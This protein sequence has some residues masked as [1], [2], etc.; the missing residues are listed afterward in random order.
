MNEVLRGQLMAA[1]IAEQPAALARLL[2]TAADQIAPIADAIRARRPRFA[3][4]AARGTSDH[5]ALYAKYLLEILAGLPVGLASP[6]TL[7]VFGSEPDL[8]EVLWIA[9]SQSGGSP[10]LVDSTTVARRGGAITLGVTN[11]SASPLAS[12]CEFHIDVH[13]GPERAVAATK[14]YSN[15]LLAL[16][17]L[18]DRL[19]GGDGRAADALPEAAQAIVDINPGAE[20][21]PRYRFVERIVT[22]GRGYA[23]PTAR[24]GALKLMETSYVAAHS[25]S[26]A[27]L[28]HGPFAMIDEDRPVVAIVPE[29]LGGEAMRPV[30][31]R[32]AERGADVLAIGDPANAPDATVTIALPRGIAEEVSPIL[33]IIPLQQLAHAMSVARGYDPDAPRGLRKVTETW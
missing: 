32:L 13:A 14:S 9:V 27:D 2:A 17:L 22:T 20:V 29:G 23:Y 12:A 33:Q 3:I 30:M 31:N 21:A 5:A 8:S 26:G 16:Y 19:R 4:L 24:E 28:L 6:S 25:F 10:D 11:A 18:I 1:E 15:Q 7:T